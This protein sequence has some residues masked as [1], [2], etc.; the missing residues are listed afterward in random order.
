MD[1]VLLF[2][3][4]VFFTVVFSMVGPMGF[5]GSSVFIWAVNNFFGL[6]IPFTFTTW[7]AGIVIIGV[8]SGSFSKR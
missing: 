7:F 5:I 1:P 8:C 6:H 4:I 2:I 3:V